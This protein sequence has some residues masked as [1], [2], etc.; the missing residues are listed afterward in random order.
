[1][2]TP[3]VTFFMMAY[4]TEKY[5]EKAIRSVLNQTESDIN[6][7]I[8]NNGSTDKTGDILDKLLKEDER[9]HV[10]T[11]KVNGITDDGIGAFERGWWY[12]EEE[13]LGEYISII[14][15]DDYLEPNFVEVMYKEAK[16]NNANFV[17]AGCNFVRSDGNVFS[18]R[19]PP[20][21]VTNNIHDFGNYF[22]YLYNTMRTWWG[23]LFEKD[24]FFKNYDKAWTPDKTIVAYKIDTTIML[25]YLSCSP[26]LVCVDKPLYNCLIRESS[27]YSARE[28]NINE[29]IFAYII[30]L[31]GTQ[32]LQRYNL[33][34]KENITFIEEVHWGYIT[35][36]AS[37]IRNNTKM[38][39]EQSYKMLE[40]I[41]IDDIVNIYMNRKFS[42]IFLFLKGILEN[43]ELRFGTSEFNIYNSFLARLSKYVDLVDANSSNPIAF[44]VYMSI[45]CDPKNRNMFGKSFISMLVNEKS[46][47]FKESLKIK[48][49]KQKW[50]TIYPDT[51]L[52]YIDSFDET[53]ELKGLEEKM[54]DLYKEDKLDDALDCAI[55]ILENNPVNLKALV[56][57][58][59]YSE[60][61]NDKAL[62]DLL[63][64]SI[65]VIWTRDVIENTRKEF[66]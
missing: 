15:S 30:Y 47:G 55:E 48:Y 18:Q 20:R 16:E 23:K 35:E 64:P 10:V 53:E 39:V 25:Y 26:V 46:Q 58:I 57:V 54:M 52:K 5:I 36:F 65:A 29:F 14:D 9:V 41:V 12:Y 42:E 28:V 6:I 13:N 62:S 61:T 2:S 49:P 45:I 43:L 27:T 21:C 31:C 56:Y 1:M 34:T 66:K 51:W 3:K 17:A 63:N 4:N 32:I 8:R 11:N 60:K 37:L 19:I 22:P 44:I 33:E 7:Y 59:L 38:T 50:W 40:A 24:F